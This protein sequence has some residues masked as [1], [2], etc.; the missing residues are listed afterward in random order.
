MSQ[1]RLTIL[2]INDTHGYLEPHPE[3]VWEPDGRPRYTT[4]GGYA[5]IATLFR[6]ARD[7]RPG[8]VVALDNGDTLHGT[9]A[10]MH[11]RGEALVEPLNALALDAMTAHWEFAWGPEHLRRTLLPRLR[12]PLL[13]INC[14]EKAGGNLAFPPSVMLD[15]DGVQVGV[16]G[17]AATIVDKT[18]PPHFAEGLR[19]TLGEAELPGHIRRLREEGADVIV[20]LSHL[21]LPQD[22]KLASRVPG[23]DVLLSGHTHNRL[24]QPIQAGGAIIMQ[25]GCH[26]SFIGRL[27]LTLGEQGGIAAADHRLIPVDET[28]EPDPAM[29]AIVEG[30]MAPHRAM[31]D[32]VV[33]QTSI[34]LDRTTMLEATMDTLLLR[35]IAA[36]AGTGLAFSN[37]WRYGAPVPPGPVT[38]SDLWN[39]IPTNPPVS[40]VELTGA[41]ILAML[42]DNLENT[43]AADPYAQMGGYAK[44]CFGLQL[45]F[46]IENPL[47]HRIDRAFA[48]GAPLD[49]GRRYRAAYVTAQGV[50]ARYGRDRHDLPIRAIDALE[51]YLRD[52]RPEAAAFDTPA[53]I[54]AV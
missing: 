18:M 4:L 33:G 29:Q 28:I 8:G 51:R 40:T 7:E 30:I 45:A 25:S 42:E 11:S 23:I 32:R 2:Q 15:R 10:A 1:R 35:A 3:I 13:A 37:G 39:I 43:F 31:L 12:H 48:E 47:G 6:R 44:R 54:S 21:G 46:K 41:E 14:Y 16:V 22:V 20:V 26:G 27:D 24:R 49:A 5:R 34:G 53:A 38:V 9:F 17:I 50:P 19:F 36:A 52:S